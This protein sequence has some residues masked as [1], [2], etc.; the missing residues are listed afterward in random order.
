M[1]SGFETRKFARLHKTGQQ[2]HFNA[3]EKHGYKKDRGLMF[4]ILL[5]LHMDFKIN[6]V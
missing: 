1:Q 6:Q 2:G 4:G 5:L 3:V